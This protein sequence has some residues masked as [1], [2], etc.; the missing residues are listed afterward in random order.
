MKINRYNF[1]FKGGRFLT[2]RKF[3]LCHWILGR[4]RKYCPSCDSIE[5][6]SDD[7]MSIIGPSCTRCGHNETTTR[8]INKA[9]KGRY[10]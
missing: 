9:I 6:F 10:K 4:K 2:V 8:I 7:G 5:Y 1:K 3:S